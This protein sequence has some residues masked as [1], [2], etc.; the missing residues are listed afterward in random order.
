MGPKVPG[1]YDSLD[2]VCEC[3]DRFCCLADMIS[4]ADRAE[5]AN[6]IQVNCAWNSYKDLWPKKTTKRSN[7]FKLYKACDP[8]VLM[9]DSE[10]LAMKAE[11]V[12]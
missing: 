6:I 2:V 10:A 8:S 5:L 4:D 12:H 3:V 9:Y 1:S 11:D 7:S